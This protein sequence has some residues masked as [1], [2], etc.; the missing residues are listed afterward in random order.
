MKL[1]GDAA[2]IHFEH[3][4]TLKEPPVSYLHGR[5]KLA[6]WLANRL[7]ESRR[8]RRYCRMATNDPGC[9]NAVVTAHRGPAFALVLSFDFLPGNAPSF[10]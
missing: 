3:V 9:A 5:S 7:I 4:T 1:D 8:E 10:C 2:R 6:C